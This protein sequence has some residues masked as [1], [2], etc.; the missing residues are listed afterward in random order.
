MTLSRD[1]LQSALLQLPRSEQL[2]LVESVLQAV[3]GE[4]P[5]DVELWWLLEA[6]RRLELVRSGEM[7]SRPVDEVFDELDR[8]LP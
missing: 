4:S 8:S 1:E 6:E 2:Q 3:P 7:S 5:A